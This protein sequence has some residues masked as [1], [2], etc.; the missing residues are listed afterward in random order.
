MRAMM[1]LPRR[2]AACRRLIDW[3]G[4]DHHRAPG[5]LEDGIAV[6]RDCCHR[7][8]HRDAA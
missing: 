2:C 3:T 6:C 8:G 4:G 7:A 5:S 1:Q